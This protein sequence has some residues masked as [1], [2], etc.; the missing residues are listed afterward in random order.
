M[1]DESYMCVSA[2]GIPRQNSSTPSFY[3]QATLD[4]DLNKQKVAIFN[5]NKQARSKQL[6]TMTNIK[7]F[8]NDDDCRRFKLKQ[9][10][11]AMLWQQLAS[12]F[13]LDMSTFFDEHR[14]T[15]T[16]GKLL[17]LYYDKVFGLNLSFPLCRRCWCPEHCHPE[18]G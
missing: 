18:H 6:A 3:H 9:C 16:H 1:V 10:T 8:Y 17:S 7:V 5:H 2:H 12:L 13:D 11:S 4:T 15:M 14:M